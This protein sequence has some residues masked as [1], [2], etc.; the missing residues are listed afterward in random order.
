MLVVV[1][2]HG[3]EDVLGGAPVRYTF[4]ANLGGYEGALALAAMAYECM[5][6][7]E[8]GR[9]SVFACAASTSWLLWEPPLSAA[10]WAMCRLGCGPHQFL[11]CA[12]AVHVHRT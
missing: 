6:M 1:C 11:S 12:S 2:S 9:P 4:V 7:D 10:V 8:A 5:S 3:T